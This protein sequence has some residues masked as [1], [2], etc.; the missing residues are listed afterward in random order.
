MTDYQYQQFPEIVTERLLLRS[1]Q[2]SDADKVF[3]LR[4]DPVVNKYTGRK[5]DKTVDDSI[6]FINKI[7]SGVDAGNCFYWAIVPKEQQQLAGTVCIWNI[8]MVEKKAELGYELLPECQGKGFIHETLEA[9]LPFGFQQ[10]KLQTIE[11]EL[12]E[13]NS[14]SIRVLESCNFVLMR[15]FLQDDA[16]M[17]TY[18]LSATR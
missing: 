10:M 13:R 7:L 14:P 12:E 2:L 4:S 5:P 1:L 16:S 8:D 18:H 3:A 6:G 9:I 11:A 17:L 15:K